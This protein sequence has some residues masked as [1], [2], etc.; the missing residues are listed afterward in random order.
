MNQH[1][2]N[3]N[4]DALR[5]FATFAVVCLH[6]SA[7]VVINKPDINNIAW[8]TGNTADAFSRWCVPVFVMISGALFF[9]NPRHLTLFE[10][11]KKKALRLLPP[12]VFWTLIY[13]AFDAYTSKELNLTLVVENI[14][15]GKPYYHLWYLYM[16]TGMYLFAPFMQSLVSGMNASSFRILIFCCF[17]VAAIE[18]ILGHLFGVKS[19][20]TF[21]P[22]FIPFIGYFLAGYYLI[23]NVHSLTNRLLFLIFLMSG[24]LIAVGTGILLPVVGE[25][26]WKIMYTYLNPIVIIMSLSVFLLFMKQKLILIS[27]SLIQRIANVSLGIYVIH[28]LWFWFLAKFKIS[29]FMIHPLIGIPIT[30][31][32]AFTLSLALASLMSRVPI[33]RKTV[34]R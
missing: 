17:A 19:W 1:H 27:P 9:S 30:A 34:A 25:R 29:P 32:L 14:I 13:I 33:L 2:H 22:R 12:I 18:S 6:V 15:T 16:I 4:L 28:P 23:N 5:V 7:S 21:L 20:S 10:F 24:L 3:T 8:W 31:I 11:F 26:S